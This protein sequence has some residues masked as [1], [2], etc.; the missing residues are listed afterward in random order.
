MKNN[1][2]SE[3]TGIFI[4]LVICAVFGVAVML[5]WNALMPP[6]FGLPQLD[7]LKSAGLLILARLLF[8]GIG[9]GWGARRDM[10]MFHHG[11][12]LREMWMNMSA[13]ERKEFIKTKEEA[14][15]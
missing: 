12:K 11:N 2:K 4:M 7:Y 8:G 13:D 1:I 14:Q 6:V 10:Y 3:I 15:K 9:G 5:L